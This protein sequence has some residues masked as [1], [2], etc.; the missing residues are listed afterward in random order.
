MFKFK[1]FFLIL[2]MTFFLVGKA[3][4]FNYQIP[5]QD[6]FDYPRNILSIK[7]GFLLYETGSSENGFFKDF[8]LTKLCLPIS[9]SRLDTN[10]KIIKSNKLYDGERKFLPN[11]FQI[12]KLNNANC[13]VYQD[14]IDE[15]HIGNIKIAVI[16]EDLLKV[17]DELT[18]LDFVKN[19][20]VYKKKKV[21][22]RESNTFSTQMSAN[23]KKLLVYTEPDR[24]KG[25]KI[26]IYLKVIDENLKT[27]TERKI[28][29]DEKYVDAQSFLCEDDGTVY[30]AYGPS[31]D[32]K[33][34][35]RSEPIDNEKKILIITPGS[36]QIKTLTFK[37][38]QFT[39]KYYR[40][41][42]S[43]LKNNVYLSGVYSKGWD[44][45]YLG[46]FHASLNKQS[47]TLSQ[48]TKTDFPLQLIQMFEKDGYAEAK[49]KNVGL[50][51]NFYPL[52]KVRGDGTVDYVLF[53][54][55]QENI[56]HSDKSFNQPKFYGGSILD[57]HILEDKV[58]FSRVGR[59]MVSPGT[60]RFLEISLFS[61]DENLII[62]YND[63]PRNIK[64]ENDEK[65]IPGVVQNSE[66]CAATI[67]KN[68]RV[69]KQ[70]LLEG[71]TG[72]NIGFLDRIY[73]ITNNSFLM[74]LEKLTF[75]NMS[76]SKT[77]FVK[78]SID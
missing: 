28:E 44:E 35:K 47:M 22:G 63:N 5:E 68:G 73:P 36:K 76:K 71:F 46:I 61:K 77:E 11:L 34:P 13:I 45:N 64:G 53:Y 23:Q 18:V 43:P 4:K 1:L 62:L 58:V 50:L 65:I 75:I 29:F 14:V 42:N 20:I 31:E 24:E 39:P 9:V 8:S 19:N 16:D 25:D 66:V 26:V 54:G 51:Q 72:K 49:K 52:T 27:I 2:F 70:Y 69:Q 10:L 12:I 57:A 30:I 15:D 17:K 74:L 40:L 60:N 41:Q 67:D 56:I 21:A 55:R 3:Q 48:V 38:D 7:N 32:G 59:D 37:L 78:I 6:K 33:I